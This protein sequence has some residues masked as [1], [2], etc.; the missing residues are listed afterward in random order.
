MQALLFFSM[1]LCSFTY[2]AFIPWEYRVSSIRQRGKKGFMLLLFEFVKQQ[3]KRVFLMT[4]MLVQSTRLS[5][6]K[7]LGDHDQALRC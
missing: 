4:S 3:S 6:A 5:R 1:L 2:E 7:L